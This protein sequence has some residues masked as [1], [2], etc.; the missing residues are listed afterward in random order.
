MYFAGIVYVLRTG[1]IWSAFPREKFGGLGS[2]ALHARFREWAR[3]GL[4]QAIWRK[5]L[6][7]Y[8]E[9]EGMA[10]EW[11]SADGAM[12]EAAL[13]QESVGPNPADRG[14]NGSKRHALVEGHGV[15]LSLIVSG[16]NTHDRKKIGELLDARVARPDDETT[17]ENLCLD[18]G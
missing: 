9:M 2:S 7:E 10:W 11:Q 15:P 13:A 5:G 3:A 17:T 1:I 14:K 6:A 4:F 16:A 12:V 18:A 8:D